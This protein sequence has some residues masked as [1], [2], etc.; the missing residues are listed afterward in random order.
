MKQYWYNTHTHSTSIMYCVYL[1]DRHVKELVWLALVVRRV[2]SAQNHLT[3]VE[4][5]VWSIQNHLQLKSSDVKSCSHLLVMHM[6][7][8]AMLLEHVCISAY[9]WDVYCNV[10]LSL[11]FWPHYV[12]N[13][14]GKASSST[15]LHITKCSQHICWHKVSRRK[16]LISDDLRPTTHLL[17]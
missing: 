13:T 2:W 6:Y 7:E 10:M 16:A 8:V 15:N 14:I 5:R 17:T 12:T 3:L 11:Y 1:I 4:S 9:M